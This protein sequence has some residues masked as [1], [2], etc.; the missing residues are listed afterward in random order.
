MA[1][2]ESEIILNFLPIKAGGG[3][4][5]ALSFTET[6][7]DLSGNSSKYIAVVSC[8]SAIH[9]LCLKLLWK[10]GNIGCA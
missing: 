6:L 3:L 9:E 7:A 10:P 8:R 5:N 1:T 4:Q 2:E